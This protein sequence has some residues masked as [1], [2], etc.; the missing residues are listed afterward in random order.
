MYIERFIYFKGLAHTVVGTGSLKVCSAGSQA[1]HRA[2]AAAL[3]WR[4]APGGIPSSLEEI[5]PFLFFPLTGRGPP[6]LWRV[7]CFVQSLLA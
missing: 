2:E 5:C 3:A 6:A 1:G 7:I 4:E